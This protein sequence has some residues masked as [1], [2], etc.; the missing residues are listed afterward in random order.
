MM[1]PVPIMWPKQVEPI[2]AARL[3]PANV[4]GAGPTFLFLI[5]A[6]PKANARMLQ[7]SM[8]AATLGLQS[9]ARTATANKGDVNNGLLL[10]Y[11]VNR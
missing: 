11:C 6:R 1:T 2:S 5:V 4:L 8:M 3:M 7:T 10:T 9:A